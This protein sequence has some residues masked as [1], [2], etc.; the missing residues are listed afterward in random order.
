[1]TCSLPLLLPIPNIPNPPH[2]H[3]EDECISF[4]QS[5]QQ[6]PTLTPPPPPSPVTSSNLKIRNFFSPFCMRFHTIRIL[7]YTLPPSP[8][9]STLHTPSSNTETTIHQTPTAPRTRRIYIFQNYPSIDFPSLQDSP[10]YS[11]IPMPIK[12][13]HLPST[14]DPG[15][16]W[17]PVDESKMLAKG[18]R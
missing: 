1:M 2:G 13:P 5:S 17:V 7:C 16:L 14:M 18:S 11:P 12:I 6:T 3:A 15:P 10:G 4:L 8:P 9:L